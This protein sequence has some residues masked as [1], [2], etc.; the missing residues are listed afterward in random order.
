M[1]DYEGAKDLLIKALAS[2]EQHHEPGHPTIATRQLN[3]GAVL[4]DLGDYD[5]AK[6]LLSKAL[7]SAEQHYEPGHPTIAV[8]RSNLEGIPK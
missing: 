4:K 8:F 5:G 7:A 1:G 3:L 6:N 2:D